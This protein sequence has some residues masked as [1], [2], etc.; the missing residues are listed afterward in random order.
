MVGK[1]TTDT[2]EGYVLCRNKGHLRLLGQQGT[3]SEY[4]TLLMARRGQ[5]RRAAT[6]K[7]RAQTQS[8]QVM[9]QCILSTASLE[10]GP[11]FVLDAIIKD[12]LFS[13]SVDGLKRVPGTSQ[14]G[15]FLYI[16]MLFQGGALSRKQ[17]RLLLEVQALLLARFQAVLP[18]RGLLW[19][20]R[21]GE[22]TTVRIGPDLRKAKRTLLELRKLCDADAAPKLILNDHCP[23]C[24]FRQRCR[25]QALQE[26]NLSLLRGL[27][28]KEV[29]GCGATAGRAYSPLPS[30]RIPSAPA[31]KGREAVRGRTAVTMPCRHWRSVTREST[32]WAR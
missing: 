6:A 3:K 4:E 5:V 26:D 25:G 27:S 28:E 1:I 24:E 20:G 18:D 12:D 11:A 23:I 13:I 19:Y 7:I 2:L 14:L 15:P 10:Q 8:L 17:Q 22:A 9:S 21:F 32:C 31:G 16:P 29:W 30:S